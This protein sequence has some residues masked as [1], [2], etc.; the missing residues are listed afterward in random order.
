M[1][2][3]QRW[4]L[5]ESSTEIVYSLALVLVPRLCEL[6]FDPS[7]LMSIDNSK[8]K[9]EALLAR[10]EILYNEEQIVISEL[11][12]ILG[13]VHDVNKVDTVNIESM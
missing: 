5:L 10:I 4:P 7:L 3:T 6:S 2:N 1:P 12:N 13:R 8:V 9:K 11:D